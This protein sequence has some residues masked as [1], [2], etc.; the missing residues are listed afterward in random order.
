MTNCYEAKVSSL[1]TLAVHWIFAPRQPSIF[2]YHQALWQPPISLY[3][4]SS[5]KRDYLRL[6]CT[7]SLKYQKIRDEA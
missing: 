1:W 4:T 2:G 6:V 5:H 7:Q 3:E